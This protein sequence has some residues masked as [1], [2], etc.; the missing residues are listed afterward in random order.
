MPTTS[1]RNDEGF[2]DIFVDGTRLNISFTPET[3]DE[4]VS[5]F[6]AQCEKIEYQLV[7]LHYRYEVAINWNHDHDGQGKDW[8]VFMEWER[9]KD[10]MCKQAGIVDT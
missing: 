3:T 4:E 5:R 8:P 2:A 10:K 9:L 1:V 6:V 7:D